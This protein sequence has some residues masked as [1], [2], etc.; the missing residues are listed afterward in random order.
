MHI[1]RAGSAALSLFAISVLVGVALAPSAANDVDDRQLCGPRCLLSVCQKL[2]INASLA[3]LASLAGDD[4][5]AGASMLGLLKAAKAKGLQGVCAK[6]SLKELSTFSGSAI[7]HLWENHFVVVEPGDRPN[8]IRVTDPP[9]QMETV[10]MGIF[11]QHYSGFALLIAKD[12][13]AFPASKVDGPDI[14]FDSYAW[15]FGSVEQGEQKEHSFK[16]RNVGNAD[17]VISKVDTSCGDCLAPIAG[18]QVIRPGGEG[19]IKVLLLTSDQTLSV[20]K[21]LYVT[22][23]D[24]VSPVVQLAVT[25]Y[26]Q[27]NQ[28]PIAPQAVVFG[29]L[30]RSETQTRKLYIPSLPEEGL[31]I[32]SVTCDSPHVV[33]VV[34]SSTES[35][36]PGYFVT[37][38]LSPCAPIGPIKA[39]ILIV[40][41]HPKQPTA[42]VP[43]TATIRSDLDLDRDMFFFGFVKKGQDRK[44][45][46]TISTIGKKPLTIGK[47]SSSL[48]Y[49]A[50]NIA[51]STEN[52]GF[53][54]T[55]SL[56]P[57]APV[58]NIRGD[59]S[60]STNDPDQP[61]IKVP[62]YAYIEE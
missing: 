21:N 48:S 30:H 9:G 20:A 53:I 38:T 58:G 27:P 57:E 19:E 26:V 4:G 6:I 60:I 40:S 47:I 5:A 28:L 3:E 11:G 1:S 12:V 29:M 50:V 61:E 36:H 23:N 49:V 13:N 45:D 15:D 46:I 7:A 10:K 37:V 31:K 35:N 24:P 44:M 32:T 62:V 8:T 25:G 22:S 59:I 18:Q 34:S 33:T 14:R 54:I 39:N 17:L 43:V 55:A 51:P 52:K 42:K 16:C 2:Q 56:K 41:N